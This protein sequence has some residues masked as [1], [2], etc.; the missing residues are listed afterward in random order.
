MRIFDWIFVFIVVVGCLFG[1]YLAIKGVACILRRRMM[2]GI[3]YLLVGIPLF[4]VLGA[5]FL[6]N[7]RVGY[8]FFIHHIVSRKMQC[9]NNLRSIQRACML[10]SVYHEAAFPTSFA[11]ITNAF[12]APE[13]FM[14]P[15]S[16]H[17]PGALACVDEWTD[18]ILVTNVSRRSDGKWI[19]AYCKPE[20][21]KGKGCNIFHVKGS[22]MWSNS[23]GFSNLTCNVKAHSRIN[24][25]N[26]NNASYSSPAAGS[27]RYFTRRQGGK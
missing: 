13:T 6:L 10:Y 19:V 25:S 18:Y 26:P 20:N 11:Q 3:G 24:E 2:S 4:L 1:L 16:G 23:E 27:K 21:H 14:C 8:S 7:T 9:M 22:V 12:L 17:K 5:P 15:C